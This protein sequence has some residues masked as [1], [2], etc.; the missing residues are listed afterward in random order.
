MVAPSALETEAAIADSDHLVGALIVTFSVIAWAEVT[1]GLRWLN[2]TLGLWL[3]A[4]PWFL[5][6]GTS[7]STGNDVAVG[8]LLLLTSLPRGTVHEYYAT[9]NRYIS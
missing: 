7:M 5:A 8:L 4:A 1:R 9:W 3:I 2:A 6:G